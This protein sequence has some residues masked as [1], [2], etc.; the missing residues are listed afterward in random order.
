MDDTYFP[1]ELWLNR[2]I[3]FASP[4]TSA[5]KLT[6]KIKESIGVLSKKESEDYQDTSLSIA[7]FECHRSSDP[8]QQARVTIYM[9]IPSKGTQALTPIRAADKLLAR[10][11]TAYK[12]RFVHVLNV[13]NEAVPLFYSSGEV[14]WVRA[15]NE[16]K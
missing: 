5:W 15:Y 10:S 12:R 14:N 13:P 4:S 6:V 8:T 16:V 11:L 7:M 1:D 2:E 9:Q 3:Q